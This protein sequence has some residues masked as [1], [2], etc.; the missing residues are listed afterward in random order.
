MFPKFMS[1]ILVTMAQQRLYNSLCKQ[2]TLYVCCM[3]K[4]N[5]WLPLGS[6]WLH[7]GVALNYC[8]FDLPTV[9]RAEI[10]KLNTTSTYT[11]ISSHCVC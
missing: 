2:C 7:L 9:K 3:Y 5:V 6:H 10:I 1:Q 11:C 4:I 8:Q